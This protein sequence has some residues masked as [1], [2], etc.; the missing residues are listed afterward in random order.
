MPTAPTTTR[1][2]ESRL[3]RVGLVVELLRRGWYSG[4]QIDSTPLMCYNPSVEDGLTRVAVAASI[5]CFDSRPSRSVLNSRDLNEGR[6]SLLGAEPMTDDARDEQWQPIAGF[7]PYYEVSDLGRVRSFWSRG[8]PRTYRA[9]LPHVL[10]PSQTTSGYPAITMCVDGKVH[11]PRKIHQLVLAAFTGPKPPGMEA[12]HLDGNRQNNTLSNLAWGT[13]T[14]NMRDK[15]RHGTQARGQDHP[16]AVLT[17]GLV[18]HMRAEHK[19]GAT[20]KDIA[21]RHGLNYETAYSAIAR[22]RVWRHV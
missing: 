2:G 20:T 9:S 16:L 5:G 8:N 3:A 6:L 4:Q 17:N 7:E 13:H 1:A 18:R 19:A 14:E 10:R 15:G 11:P 12:R 22:T 21:E